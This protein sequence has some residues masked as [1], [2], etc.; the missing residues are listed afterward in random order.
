MSHS[1]AERAEVATAKSDRN[2]TGRN[3][4]KPYPGSL[5]EMFMPHNRTDKNIRGLQ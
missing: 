5:G 3:K 2:R 4:K 1:N